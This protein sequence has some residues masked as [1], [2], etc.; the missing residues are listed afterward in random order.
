MK[1]K[2]NT[3]I[4]MNATKKPNGFFE[5][6]G[7]LW[8][9]KIVCDSNLATAKISEHPNKNAKA[10]TNTEMATEERHCLHL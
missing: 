6:N 5:S 1:F 7:N 2:C 8:I 9:H 4:K 3:K 10:L